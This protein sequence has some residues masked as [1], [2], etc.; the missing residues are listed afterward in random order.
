MRKN[1]M[2][3]AIAT[4][5]LASCKGGFK[6]LDGGV[7]YNIHEDKSGPTIQ[8]G[9]FMSLN[10]IMKTEGDSVLGSTYEIGT[11]ST[12]V[13]PKEQRKGDITAAFLKLSEGDS[14]TVKL[15]IDS[16]LKKGVPRPPG[17]K[18]KY[19]VY[20]VKVE[21]VIPKGNLTDS[22]F[23]AK[24]SDYLKAEA[25]KIK[26][27]EPAK[28]KKYVEDNKL[29]T[30]IT[31][32]GLQYVIT[33]PGTGPTAANGDTAVVNYTCKLLS[34]KFIQSSIKEV[35]IKEKA[36]IDPRQPFE[37]IHIPIGEGKVIKG[38]D[39]G[40]LLLNKGAKAT[41]IIPSN[42]AWDEQ[43]AP[44]IPPYSPVVFDVE[45]VDIIHP[46]K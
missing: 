28:L 13:M 37:P 7:L 44:S 18:G 12:N 3:I 30:T 34:G 41:F 42:L 17:I 8:P 33:K 21:K 31:P 27:A 14:A 45:M 39:E 4:L 9:D 40:L 16:I 2:F 46:K 43:G 19:I 38:W 1:L 36:Q 29:K 5:G 20:E 11:P 10:L 15:T 26:A 6:Q 22:V 32:S 35:A 23:Q 25:D 24:I